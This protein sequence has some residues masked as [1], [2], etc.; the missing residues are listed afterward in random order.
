MC[1]GVCV[2]VVGV[3]VCEHVFMCGSVYVC[4][5]MCSC[6][7]M[8]VCV[9]LSVCIYVCLSNTTSL[10]LLALLQSCLFSVTLSCQD[11]K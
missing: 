1:V 5:C 7:A 9:Y 8:H 4:D 11:K 3:G 2:G 10:T 6:L